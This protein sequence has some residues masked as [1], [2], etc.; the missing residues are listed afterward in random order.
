MSQK[1]DIQKLYEAAE[2]ARFDAAAGWP[3]EVTP[4]QLIALWVGHEYLPPL[5]EPQTVTMQDQDG[6][7]V[8]QSK[9]PDPRT[10]ERG[11]E[12]EAKRKACK[13]AAAM[14]RDAGIEPEE[15]TETTPR[16]PRIILRL[17]PPGAI[18]EEQPPEVRKWVVVTRDA[19]QQCIKR[20]GMPAPEYIR[21]W[22]ALEEAHQ[23]ETNE[24]AKQQKPRGRKPTDAPALLAQILDALESYAA[25]TGQDFDR[26]TMPGPLGES[27]DDDGSFHWLCAHLYPGTFKRAKAT[28][29]KHRAGICAL[30]SYAKP[31]DFYRLALPH[32]APKLGVTL[33][34]RHMP[35]KGRKI[36]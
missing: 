5:G 34:V 11:T 2:F 1:S 28:F 36:A 27:F 21:A 12:T 32:I 15:R 3:S 17:R 7:I 10:W 20:L 4:T 35:K 25:A 33:N 29:E 6:R 23:G 9:Q 8:H 31:T 19:V 16:P 18:E 14:L 24:P 13:V 30:G 22:L 26:H